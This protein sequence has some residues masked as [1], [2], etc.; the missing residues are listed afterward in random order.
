MSSNTVESLLALQGVVIRGELGI[1]SSA[2]MIGLYYF[3]LRGLYDEQSYNRW[4]A[5]TESVPKTI[6]Q[7][8]SGKGSSI[9]VL[10]AR[11]R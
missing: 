1:M 5:C 3:A 9:N 2:F 7:I 8:D 6:L 10:T 4:I 11:M